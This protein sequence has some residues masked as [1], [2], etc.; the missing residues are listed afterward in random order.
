MIELTR[1]QTICHGGVP[2]FVVLP[3]TD[4]AREFPKE[5][6]TIWQKGPWVPDSGI[7]H[8]VVGL[9]IKQGMTLL[10]AWREYLGLT[11]ADL[12]EKV[13]ISQAALSKM[14]SGEGKLRKATRI[15]LATA[16]GIHPE[17]LR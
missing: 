16:L 6:E 10:K 9:H 8:A 3:F 4:F 13:G 5:A 2:A 7:P 17:Q 14:E 15:K 1:L 12:A 11:Q